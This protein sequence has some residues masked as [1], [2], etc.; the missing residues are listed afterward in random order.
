MVERWVLFFT[1]RAAVFFCIL[2]VCSFSVFFAAVARP[3]KTPASRQL[4]YEDYRRHVQWRHRR[5]RVSTWA[6]HT[7]FVNIY[8]DNNSNNIA[9]T[10]RPHMTKYLFI[11]IMCI[12]NSLCGSTFRQGV[13]LQSQFRMMQPKIF[14][15]TN[16]TNTVSI[17]TS[18]GVWDRGLMTRP[19]SDWPRSW[20]YTFGL[21]SNTVC[22]DKTLCDMINAEM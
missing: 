3:K 12:N 8:S 11:S 1:G 19:V 20:S 22:V 16:M 6:D 15:V 2:F 21:A 13:Q 4:L 7:Q 10:H 5:R 17:E 18:L 9:F 14:T